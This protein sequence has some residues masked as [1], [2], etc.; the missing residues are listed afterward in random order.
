LPGLPTQFVFAYGSLIDADSRD[1][2]AGTML[3]AIPVRVS[4]DFGFLRAWV[5]RCSCGF[6]G[7][8]LRKPRSGEAAM[9]I[10]GVIFAVDES[11]LSSLDRREDG[12]RRVLVPPTL[13]EA[14]SWKEIPLTGQIWVYVPIGSGG[15]P[16]ADLPEPTAQ[17]RC[18]RVISTSCCVAP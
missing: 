3:P 12:Y 14:V 9:T 5:D 15:E 18:Y 4:A 16:G 2:T 7:L 6:T 1:R 11:N 10:N 8:G 13:V 17:F